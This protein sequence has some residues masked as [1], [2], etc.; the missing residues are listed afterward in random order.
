MKKNKLKNYLL[1]LI[2]VTVMLLGMTGCSKLRATKLIV[3]EIFGME[4]ISDT[5]YVN[6]NMSDEARAELLNNYKKA[7]N[8]IKLVYGDV[9]SNPDVVA[10]STEQCYQKFSGVSAR[11]ISYGGSTFLLSPRGL[12]SQIISHEWSH[13]ELYVRIDNFWKMRNIPQWFDEGMAVVVSGEPTHSMEVWHEIKKSDMPIPSLNELESLADWFAA[14]ETYGGHKPNYFNPEGLKVV[15]ATAGNEVRTWLDTVGRE[16]F[17][18][19]IK[20]VKSGEDF[21]FV[22]QA[23]IR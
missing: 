13:N 20:Q 11:A 16:G 21:A 17:L 4:K 2:V 1:A 7:R 19:L 18:N 9:L 10:C 22:Y 15:Y 23:E 12:T 6:E 5:V 8:N 3:P 14:I